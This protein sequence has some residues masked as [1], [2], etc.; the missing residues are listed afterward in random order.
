MD[1]RTDANAV[2]ARPIARNG[3]LGWD[4]L[5]I[6]ASTLCLFHCLALPVLIAFLPSIAEWADMGETFH[7]AMLAIAFPLSGL[8]LWRGWRRHG[9]MRPLLLGFAGLGLLLFGVMFEGERIGTLLTVAGGI[10]LAA[11]HLANLR[12]ARLSYLTSL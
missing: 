5:A 2:M 9:G 3:G 8:T 12:A 10:T 7:I 6:S 1:S 11:A 4:G